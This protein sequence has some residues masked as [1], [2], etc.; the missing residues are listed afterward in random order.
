MWR[1]NWT[2]SSRRRELARSCGLARGSAADRH[3]RKLIEDQDCHPHIRPKCNPRDD[4]AHSVACEQF[5]SEAVAT[6]RPHRVLQSFKDCRFRPPYLPT[7]FQVIGD[8]YVDH[9]GE[10]PNGF[11]V[12]RSRIDAPVDVALGFQRPFI[13]ILLSPERTADIAAFPPHLGSPTSGGELDDHW[14][15]CA[16]LEEFVC[17][18][19]AVRE[20][21]L[22]ET[23][24]I[25][26]KRVHTTTF[27]SFIR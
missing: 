25:L 27:R 11:R 26:C 21:K 2:G 15:S 12:G 18:M 23:P 16:L 17:A 13:G 1:W 19:C 6:R 5:P 4:I 20:R 7:G 14:H 22:N 8:V 9:V 3:A 10:S 24:E